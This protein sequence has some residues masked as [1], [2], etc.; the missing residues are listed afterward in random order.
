MKSGEALITDNIREEPDI[1][2]PPTA[3]SAAHA[4]AAL[5]VPLQSATG[6][7]GAIGLV[8]FRRGGADSEPPPAFTLA[9]LHFFMGVAAHVAGGLELSQAVHSTRATDTDLWGTPVALPELNG[10]GYP[11]LSPDQLTIFLEAPGGFKTATRPDTASAFS[12]PVAVTG[13]GTLANFADPFIAP[14]GLALYF[15]GYVTAAPDDIYVATRPCL[16]H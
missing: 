4:R 1:Y 14:D 16:A 9:D 13:L 11:S 3:L 10:T 2:L 12:T 15:A 7:L 6:V 8:R 5:I